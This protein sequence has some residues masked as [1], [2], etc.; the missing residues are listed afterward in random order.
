MEVEV[1]YEKLFQVP[2]LRLGGSSRKFF[3]FTEF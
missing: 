1:N 3:Y 2:V